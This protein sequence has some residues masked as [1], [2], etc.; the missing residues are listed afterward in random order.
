[1]W[2]S[3]PDRSIEADTLLDLDGEAI[4]LLATPGHVPS[5]LSVY[6]PRSKV[7]F[8]GDAVYQGMRPNT[9]FAGPEERA[10]WVR[11]LRRL[12]DLDVEVVVPGHGQVCGVD[13]IERNIAMLEG[14]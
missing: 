2:Y 10:E 6:V 8:A 4:H 13:E 14:G 3:L 11:Q 7:L 9:R 1:M 5:E 12:K